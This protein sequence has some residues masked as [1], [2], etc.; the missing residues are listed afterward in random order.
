MLRITALPDTPIATIQY[1]TRVKASGDIEHRFVPVI[2]GTVDGLPRMVAGLVALADLQGSAG[3][4]DSPRLPAFAAIAT[5]EEL[6]R[7]GTIPPLKE[8]IAICAGDL[9]AHLT[10]HKGGG[11]GDVRE[12]W[13]ALRDRFLAVVGVAGNHDM[14]GES[15]KDYRQ[16]RKTPHVHLLDADSARIGGLQFGGVSGVIGPTHKP[17]RRSEEDF[18]S[19]IDLVLHGSPDVLVLHQGPVVDAGQREACP[20]IRARCARLQ[21]GVVVYGH[22]RTEKALEMLPDGTQFLSVHERVVVLVPAAE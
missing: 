13:L 10:L 3:E 1:R 9:W 15:A 14:F 7:A 2:L 22:D 16:F 4:V 18:L 21:R 20:G 6:E 5:L 11:L 17:F 8:M 19:A 12:A